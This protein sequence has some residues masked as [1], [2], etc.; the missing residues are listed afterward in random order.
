MSQIQFW[1]VTY[2]VNLPFSVILYLRLDVYEESMIVTQESM[3]D[4]TEIFEIPP[5]HGHREVFDRTIV[6]SSGTLGYNYV[7]GE[8]TPLGLR[9]LIW[10][11][12]RLYWFLLLLNEWF[13]M[14]KNSLKTSI[15]KKWVKKFCFYSRLYLIS[16]ILLQEYKIGI[17]K[18]H[19]TLIY[20]LKYDIVFF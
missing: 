2:T 7:N 8:V 4:H 9:T 17:W 14:M 6:S 12:E 5:W 10:T 1:N 18:L 3:E 20:F 11:S 13:F 16:C 15:W 19:N